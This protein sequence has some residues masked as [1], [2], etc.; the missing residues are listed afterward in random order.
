M[1]VKWVDAYEIP[2]RGIGS[3]NPRDNGGDLMREKLVVG[4]RHNKELW[5]SIIYKV[6]EPQYLNSEAIEV[7]CLLVKLV[8]LQVIGDSGGEEL[9]NIA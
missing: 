8:I 6:A 9:E 1:L 3:K 5:K 2:E 4:V 7:D